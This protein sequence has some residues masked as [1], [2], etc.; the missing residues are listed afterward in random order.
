MKT[1]VLFTFT[2]L[3]FQ[4][5]YSRDVVS[6]IHWVEDVNTLYAHLE[7][8]HANFYHSANEVELRKAFDVAKE[9]K[10]PELRRIMLAQ[11]LAKV[12]DGH[13]LLPLIDLPIDTGMNFQY[14]PVQF[15]QFDDGLYIVSA[16]TS[17][18]ALIGQKVVKF[19]GD[20]VSAVLSRIKQLISKDNPF[21]E[22][23]IANYY[24][25]N[26]SLVNWA[27]GGKTDATTSL[28]LL[29]D[30]GQ[31]FIVLFEKEEYLHS[32][33][34]I[35]SYFVKD[36]DDPEWVNTKIE[37][38]VASCSDNY[39]K[40]IIPHTKIM[41]IEIKALRDDDL[42][43]SEF[44][45]GI[46]QD[47]ES[48]RIEKMIVDIRLNRGGN[49]SKRWPL[50][51]KLATHEIN[52]PKDLVV[53]TSSRVFSAGMML[54][55]DLEQHTKATFIGENTGSSPNHYGETN[56]FQLP[57]SKISV[58]YSSLYWQNS[59]PN[60]DRISIEPD[61]HIDNSSK[62]FFSG[63]D[64]AINIAINYLSADKA[65]YN[66]QLSMVGSMLLYEKSNLDG[67]NSGNIAVYHHDNYNIESFKW[68]VGSAH[69]TI[70]RAK[71]NPSTLIVD[72]FDASRMDNLGK[73]THSL[74][75]TTSASNT[76]DVTIGENH[77]YLKT[78]GLPW[79][80]YDFDFAS[81]GYIYPHL[82]SKETYSFE[83]NDFDLT[84]R[85]IALK[86][87]GRVDMKFL[88]IEEYK[89]FE[90]RKYSIDGLGLNN[91]GGEIWFEEKTGTLVAFAIAK[92]DE[93]GYVS[94]KL[95]LKSITQMSPSEWSNFK[96]NSL[97]Q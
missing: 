12:G 57:H 40:V 34:W 67:S 27:L 88:G 59:R 87:F 33:Q 91:K 7:K 73:E 53:L 66:D 5:A 17:H 20:S 64:E 63:I 6:E 68:R 10:D 21:W 62:L 81:L 41:Y 60:D 35:K 54:A 70:V 55:T 58:L 2:A 48:Q 30:K 8:E 79:H 85:P 96:V 24:L 84:A 4:T 19:G 97:N 18:S 45:D 16:S 50:I 83:I 3:L 32:I 29:N 61:I 26:V 76:L 39:C 42:V 72:K 89:S 93:P 25:S 80:S 74:S 90:T 82:K 13:T 44:V 77:Q 28:T 9:A 86:K 23:D 11:A 52:N 36:S 95:E 75:L 14:L 92:P 1:L 22:A 49:G 47:I 43:F 38:P 51:Y 46:F 37:K 94:G 69:A 15:K 78:Y 31:E 56:V 71:M 65:E